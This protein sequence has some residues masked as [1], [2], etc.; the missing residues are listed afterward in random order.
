M[1]GYEPADLAAETRRANA[2][3]RSAL[4]RTN[5]DLALAKKLVRAARGPVPDVGPGVRVEVH[6]TPG[7]PTGTDWWDVS[8]VGSVVRVVLADTAGPATPAGAMVPLFVRS[9]V[10]RHLGLAPGRLLD[11][12]NRD[13]IAVGIDD[14]PVVAISVLQFD[15]D[16]GRYVL[17]RGGAPRPVVTT[18]TGATLDLAPTGPLLGVFDDASFGVTEGEIR[19]G[20]KIILSSDGKDTA[21][22]STRVEVVRDTPEKRR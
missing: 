20:E 12:V 21:D 16:T 7:H 4:A 9:L 22:D 2:R 18:E 15:G 6:H 10:A 17:A 8:R 3:L 5:A 11:E 13:L 14:P 1:T 19:A